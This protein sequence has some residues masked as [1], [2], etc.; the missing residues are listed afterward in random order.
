MGTIFFP[1]TKSA[2]AWLQLPTLPI[3][4]KERVELNLYCPVWGFMSCSS[5]NL[6]LICRVFFLRNVGRTGFMRKDA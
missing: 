4:V 5:V 3:E 1:G 2:G 6:F